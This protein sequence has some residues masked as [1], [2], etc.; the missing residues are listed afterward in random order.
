MKQDTKL[1]QWG[2]GSEHGLSPRTHMVTN[3]WNPVPILVDRH[4]HSQNTQTLKKKKNL[5]NLFKKK[6]K[7]LKSSGNTDS[8]TFNFH[9]L[10]H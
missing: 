2:N 7:R 8:Q 3:V 4:T 10:E 1:G 5:S 6:D 9:N